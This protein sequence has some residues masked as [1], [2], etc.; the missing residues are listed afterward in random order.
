LAIPGNSVEKG[1]GT[2]FRL[3]TAKVGSREVEVD[4]LGPAVLQV[5]FPFPVP[6]TVECSDGWYSVPFFPDSDR[7]VRHMVLPR[8]FEDMLNVAVSNAG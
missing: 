6:D 5:D 1:A 2:P 4:S 3:K 7:I 8:R